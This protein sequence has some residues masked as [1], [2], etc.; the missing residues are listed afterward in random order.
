[1][2]LLLLLSNATGSFLSREVIPREYL[3]HTCG[4]DTHADHE[5]SGR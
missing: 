1:M 4:A 2:P 3:G 5:R